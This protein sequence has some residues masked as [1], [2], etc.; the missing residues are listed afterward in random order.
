M[1]IHQLMV[2]TSRMPRVERVVADH[3]EGFRRESRL[4]LDDVVEVLIMSPGEHDIIQT[5]VRAV[6]AELRAVDLVPVVRVILKGLGAVDNAVV[7]GTAHGEGIADNI[8]LATGVEE[9]EQF[10]EIVDQA[11]ELHPARLAVTPD[12]LGGLEEV[13][14]LREGS[15]RVRLVD[16]RVEF[17]HG[18]PDGHVRAGLGVVVLAGFEVVGDCLLGVL[19]LVEVLDAVACVFVLSELR[20]VFGLVELGF[21]VQVFFIQVV[22]EHVHAVDGVGYVLEGLAVSCGVECRW[23]LG[24]GDW[25]HFG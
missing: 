5:A 25:G 17:L 24:D 21:F 3:G 22:F 4:V 7:K 18:F 12:G 14:D 8:P 19:F 20:L 2:S 11:R 15:V 13:V 9:E 1:I 23:H 6:D 16:E 10:A